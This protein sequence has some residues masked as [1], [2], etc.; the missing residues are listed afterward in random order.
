MALY[1]TI[2]ICNRWGRAHIWVCPWLRDE[3]KDGPKRDYFD[4][5]VIRLNGVTLMKQGEHFFVEY[6]RKTSFLAF[7]RCGE[8]GW[9]IINSPYIDKIERPTKEDFEN[10]KAF[11][12]KSLNSSFTGNF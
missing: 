9:H 7:N 4:E 12:V 1:R 5:W 8:F 6:E 10:L 2:H 3:P 11:N